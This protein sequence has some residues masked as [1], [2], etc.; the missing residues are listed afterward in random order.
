MISL[1]NIDSRGVH[2]KQTCGMVMV[3]LVLGLTSNALVGQKLLIIHANAYC[4]YAAGQV[5]YVL[6]VQCL[7]SLLSAAFWVMGISSAVNLHIYL[8]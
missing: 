3:S 4:K 2:Y 1:G 6:N 7:K 5:D 8:S